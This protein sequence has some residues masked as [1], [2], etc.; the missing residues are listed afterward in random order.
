LETTVSPQMSRRKQSKGS[1]LNRT[2][3]EGKPRPLRVTN[4]LN[5]DRQTKK[6]QGGG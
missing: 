5:T 2:S 3:K 4:I 1:G 6:T